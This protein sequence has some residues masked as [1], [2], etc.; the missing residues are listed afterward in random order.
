MSEIKSAEKNV[1]LTSQDGDSFEV[2]VSVAKISIV[3]KSILDEEQEDDDDDNEIPLP[4]VK[5]AILSKVI[6]FAQHHFQEAMI[7]IEKVK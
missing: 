5:T 6:E 1:K 7:E 3:V 4:N 2:P